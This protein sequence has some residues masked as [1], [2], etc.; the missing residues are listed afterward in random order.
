MTR[1]ILIA[2]ALLMAVGS[3]GVAY[4]VLSAHRAVAECT[5]PC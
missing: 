5:R 2:L 3:A 4:A 1:R